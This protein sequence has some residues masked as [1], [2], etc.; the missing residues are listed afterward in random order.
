MADEVV[1]IKKSD[2]EK[3]INANVEAYNILDEVTT[4]ATDVADKVKKAFSALEE[5]PSEIGDVI[6]EDDGDVEEEK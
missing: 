3:I 4:D 5:A 1:K 6:V 2:L